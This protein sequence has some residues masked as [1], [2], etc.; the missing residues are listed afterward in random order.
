MPRKI[1]DVVDG[2]N[3]EESK[4]EKIRGKEQQDKVGIFW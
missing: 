2:W 3:E 4:T 1:E